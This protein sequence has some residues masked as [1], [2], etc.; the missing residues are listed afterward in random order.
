MRR[1]DRWIGIPA[2]A[3]LSAFM[4]IKRFFMKPLVAE[5]SVPRCIMFICLAETGAL[6]LA[7]QAVDMAR[8]RFPDVDIM[9]MT[10]PTGQP[11]LEMMG[12]GP[13]HRIIL[14]PGSLLRLVGSSLSAMVKARRFQVDATVNLEVYA[15]FS[16]LMSVL[17]GA[18]HR[19]GYYAFNE[20]GG[21]LGELITHRTIYS[22]HHHI[23][24]VYK[25]LVAALAESGGGGDAQPRAKQDPKT[26][27][28]DP[29][30]LSPQPHRL[31]RLRTRLAQLAPPYR[32]DGKLVLL[33]TNTSDL[34]MARRW[35]AERYLAL[36]EKFLQDSELVVGFT[37][38][39]A[40]REGVL[41]LVQQFDHPR[42]VCLAG[43]TSLAELVDLF[44]LADLMVTN[45]SGP[46]HF[47]SATDMPTLV[48]FGPETPRIFGP[49]GAR[50]KALYLGLAC[51]PCVSVYNQK[52]SPCSDNVC[53]TSITV[54]HVYGEA[55]SMMGTPSNAV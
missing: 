40:E 1:I 50:Q 20:E 25:T 23:T 51:S 11:M 29:L 30:R 24:D 32:P 21:Y 22:P 49:I 27:P 4:C 16:T 41:S 34:V 9:F 48:L 47:A 13:E 2:C 44:H 33:N 53:M 28:G 6:I 3:V 45:D 5:T 55:M 36:A 12:I 52:K 39:P 46:A 37:G 26:W 43:E 31:S 35:P 14:D 19:A 42:A 18:R 17:V 7:H 8:R 54:D 15:R 38:A 10:F